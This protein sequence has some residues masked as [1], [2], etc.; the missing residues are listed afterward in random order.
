MEPIIDHI[1]ITVQDLDAA[2]EFYDRLMP[3][4]GFDLSQKGSAEI[5]KHDFR[6][7]EYS[8][9]KLAFALTSP[10]EKFKDTEV[11]RRRPGSLHHLAFRAEETRGG[12]DEVQGY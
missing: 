5:E 1:Q 11:H 7:V 6:V 3:L 10:R 8:H 12:D 4:L 2:V 9:P